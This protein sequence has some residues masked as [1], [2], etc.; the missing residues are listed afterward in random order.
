MTGCCDTKGPWKFWQGL[1]ELER[2]Q[3]QLK[4]AS[5]AHKELQ[6]SLQDTAARLAAELDVRQR[7]EQQAQQAQ[8][9][10]VAAEQQ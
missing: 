5:M 1:R 3:C 8:L 4:E 10:L 9:A 6:Q 2:L 7:A